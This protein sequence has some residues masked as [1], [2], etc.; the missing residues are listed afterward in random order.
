MKGMIVT[1]AMKVAVEPAAPRTPS[2]LSQNPASRRVPNVHSESL[3]N[4]AGVDAKPPDQP[5]QQRRLG[6]IPQHVLRVGCRR[7]GRIVEIQKADAVRLAG[8]KALWKD[9]GQRLLDDTC[10][11]RTCRHEEDGCWPSFA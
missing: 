8:A 4:D 5:I 3:L 7:Y 11:Q 9:V 6:E 10:Q 1:V 2:R